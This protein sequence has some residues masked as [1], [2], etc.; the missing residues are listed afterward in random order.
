MKE[1]RVSL[2]AD[3]SFALWRDHARAFLG[4]GVPPS[5]V[6]WECPSGQD[7]LFSMSE[8]PLLPVRASG[9]RV[10]RDCLH[11]LETVLCHESVE[12]FDL[13]Y[14]I[15]WR[16]RTERALLRTVTDPD[17]IL[18]RRMCHQIRHDVHK[19]KAFV[20]FRE[21]TP[22][23]SNTRHF[24]AWFEPEHHVLERVASFFARRFTDMNWIILTPRGSIGWDGETCVVTREICS[25]EIVEDETEALW[26]T[27]YRSI[28][29]PARVKVK[30]MRS[31]MS[32]KYWKN[33]PETELIPE[34]LAEAA[35][36][37]W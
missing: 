32:P 24:V 20:R 19:M 22:E 33:L 23:G 4:A 34:M 35:R 17:M 10:T 16:S 31:E 5:L 21:R 9:G 13:A 29:N 2:P 7:D 26:K 30:A 15:L 6:I 36:K 18:A 11:L 14:R 3:A 12:R 28:F 8:T 37:V 27:Y 25:R 1:Y